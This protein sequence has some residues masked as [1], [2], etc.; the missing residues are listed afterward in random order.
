[1]ALVVHPVVENANN[2]DARIVSLE[3][4]AMAAARG[5]QDARPEVVAR[6]ATVP[7]IKPFIVSRRAAMYWFVRSGPHV[8]VE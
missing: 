5:H 7:R 8:R 6:V 2:Q 4:D 3:E 1:M